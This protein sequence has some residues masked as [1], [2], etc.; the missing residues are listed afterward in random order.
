MNIL[1]QT[2]GLIT[3]GTN[4][5]IANKPE[6]LAGMSLVGLGATAYFSFQAGVKVQASYESIKSFKD[7]IIQNHSREALKELCKILAPAAAATMFTGACIVGSQVIAHR[8]YGALMAAYMMGN[9]K[10]KAF[11][12]SAAKLLDENK[13]DEV[14]QEIAQQRV[15]AN[16]VTSHSGMVID[17]GKGSTLCLDLMSGRYFKSSVEYIRMAQNDINE[18]ITGDWSATLNDFY[19]FLGLD[20]IKLGDDL[21]WNPNNML[22]LSFDSCLTSSGEPV[23]VM[24]YEA[25]PEYRLL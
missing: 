18:Q 23:L 9:D 5:V 11:E 17:T 8:Q 20:T 24:D 6:I 13:M 10:L 25:Y 14:R 21:G 1:T 15:L 22:K 2:K 16:P 12:S 3:K 4:L 7:D 19:S